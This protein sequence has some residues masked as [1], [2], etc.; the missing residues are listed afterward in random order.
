MRSHV[1]NATETMDIKRGYEFERVWSTYMSRHPDQ[2]EAV[3]AFKE[4][5]Q[6]VYA[7]AERRL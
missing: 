3:H 2:K 4:R 6:P 7:S 5:R 1:L